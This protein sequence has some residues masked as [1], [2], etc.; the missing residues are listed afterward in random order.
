MKQ[1][2]KF[3]ITNENELLLYG[4][5]YNNNNSIISDNYMLGGTHIGRYIFTGKYGIKLEITFK[6]K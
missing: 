5:Q 1:I 4:C 6:I 2:N 3:I